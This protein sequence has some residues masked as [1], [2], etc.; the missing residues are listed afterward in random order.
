MRLRAYLTMTRAGIR[1]FFRDP[2]Q[3]QTS[4]IVAGIIPNVLEGIDRSLSASPPLLQADVEP[5]NPGRDRDRP[6]RTIDFLLPGILAMTIM[7]LGL[8]TAI[9]LISMR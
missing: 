8:F 2:C 4:Q 1:A 7:Q 5:L 9:P 3:R 6:M